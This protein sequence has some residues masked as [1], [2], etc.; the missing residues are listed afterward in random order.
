MKMFL[1][2]AV[3]IGVISSTLGCV[4]GTVIIYTLPLT[5]DIMAPIISP[6]IIGIAMV[7][8]IA[9]ST[10]AGI[11]PAWRASKMNIVEAIKNV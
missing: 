11:Y 6:S 9:V 3:L 4:L 8:G 10:I 2:E 5:N 1:I 7:L